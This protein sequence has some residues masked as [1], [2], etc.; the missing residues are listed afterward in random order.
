MVFAAAP[1]ASDRTL[2]R[3]WI[4]IM[5][6]SFHCHG[7][8]DRPSIVGR[9]YDAGMAHVTSLPKSRT[10]N[11]FRLFPMVVIDSPSL[12]PSV[13]VAALAVSH[14]GGRQPLPTRRDPRP[15]ATAKESSRL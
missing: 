6:L 15:R 12:A 8:S 7:A 5:C 4:L 14:R 9:A 11:L 1:M 10:H 13:G 2:R 3:A